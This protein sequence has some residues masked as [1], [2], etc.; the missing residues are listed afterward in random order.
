MNHFTLMLYEAGYGERSGLLYEGDLRGIVHNLYWLTAAEMGYL[1]LL[2]ALCLWWAVDFL[3]QR[4]HLR[5]LVLWVAAGL[6]LAGL[7]LFAA[8]MAINR[9]S[10]RILRNPPE[11]ERVPPVPP[12]AERQHDWGIARVY[13]SEAAQTLRAALKATE[14]PRES[15]TR[16]IP[17]GVSGSFAVSGRAESL[18][19][20]AFETWSSI[21]MAMA[22]RSLRLTSRRRS[23]A[24]A[25][26]GGC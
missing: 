4:P 7:A 15:W 23:R 5:G 10:D 3:H 17:S 25:F 1:G 14:D 24:S 2:A 19:R 20:A 11:P 21:D 12:S 18:R 9:Q 6:G 26:V 13:S 16:A 22:S 8:G